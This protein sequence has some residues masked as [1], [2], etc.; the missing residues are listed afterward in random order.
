KAVDALG[1]DRVWVGSS[2]SLLHV[3]Y[4]LDNETNEETLS[5][6][7][8]NWLA[9]AKQKLIEINDLATLATQ[10]DNAEV[11]QRF[12][13]NKAA[14]NSRRTSTLIHKED[15]KKR[16]AAITDEDSKRTSK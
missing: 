3:P 12:E 14:Q 1:K 2:C 9:F 6:E 11:N 10:D 16:V 13:D 4:D 7:I 8:K 5:K 15:V